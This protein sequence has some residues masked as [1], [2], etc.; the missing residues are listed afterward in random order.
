LTFNSASC[1]P[2]S[3]NFLLAIIRNR[4]IEVVDDAELQEP[5]IIS[6]HLQV[7][8]QKTRSL[9]AVPHPTS[10]LAVTSPPPAGRRGRGRGREGDKRSK[11][12]VKRVVWSGGR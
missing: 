4:A 2:H 3:P 1:S 10:F 8:L 6:L 9:E 11:R 7:G 5:D 12:E